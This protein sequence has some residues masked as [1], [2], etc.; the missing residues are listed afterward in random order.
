[1]Q[2]NY[3]KRSWKAVT[4]SPGWFVT[5]LKLWLVGLIP[6]FGGIVMWGH[7]GRWCRS[8]ANGQEVSL[9]TRIFDNSDGMLYRSGLLGWGAYTILSLILSTVVGLTGQ[10]FAF[11]PYIGGLFSFLVS[12]ALAIAIPAAI[13]LSLQAVFL[14]SF[15]MGFKF[16]QLMRAISADSS[17][18]F[19]MMLVYL[20]GFAIITF[21]STILVFAVALFA[22]ASASGDMSAV[23]A[24]L[25]S[26]SADP[27]AVTESQAMALLGMLGTFFVALIPV[28]VVL[29]FAET[30]LMALALPAATYWMSAFMNPSSPVQRPY[31][32]SGPG[33]P[34]MGPN[35]PM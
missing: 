12:F 10:V 30:F 9:P 33:G 3:L 32:M 5:L 11:I 7:L 2:Q 14:D 28:A 18:Y 22:V 21:L 13:A 25:E 26:I 20:I 24:T 34:Y 29:S 8:L 27:D 1:M 23:M 4:S 19:R 6:V 35:G 17:A 15:G 16:D 31:F